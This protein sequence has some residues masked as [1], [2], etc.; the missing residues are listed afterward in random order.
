MNASSPRAN[1]TFERRKNLRVDRFHEIPAVGFED[2]AAD[3]SES[4]PC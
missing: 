1:E 2:V 3:V 4:A